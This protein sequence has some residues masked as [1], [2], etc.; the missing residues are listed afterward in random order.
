MP[1]APSSRSRRYRPSR[2]VDSRSVTSDT[3]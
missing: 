3:P 1:P 2:A